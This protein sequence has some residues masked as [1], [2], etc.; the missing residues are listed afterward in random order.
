MGC[1]PR[2][3][4][5]GLVGAVAPDHRR[6]RSHPAGAVEAE[7]QRPAGHRPL[8]GE[9]PLGQV[10]SVAGQG[11]EDALISGPVRAEPSGGLAKRAGDDTGPAPIQRMGIG[12][13]RLQQPDAARHK[14]EALE[15]GRGQRQRM[16][17]RA[18]VVLE[19]WKRQLL[20][21]AASARAAGTLQ[22][23]NP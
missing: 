13:L 2:E 8:G 14:V 6:R 5:S 12:H 17:R 21:A 10:V 3:E 16:G 1:H 9:D 4:G 23:K 15:E 7:Q 20:G 11:A 19:P 18:D 22:D